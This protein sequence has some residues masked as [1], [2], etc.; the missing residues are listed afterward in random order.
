M[1]DCKKLRTFTPIIP[2]GTG[3]T[4]TKIEDALLEITRDL[5]GMTELGN[6]DYEEKDAEK[7]AQV[8]KDTLFESH[9]EW[10]DGEYPVIGEGYA[11]QVKTMQQWQLDQMP[12]FNG[13]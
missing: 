9:D 6:F 4:Y 8:L 5:Y 10:I 3:P 7:L 12:E 13:Y 11:L 1:L 2:A